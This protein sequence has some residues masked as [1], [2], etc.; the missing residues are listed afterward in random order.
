MKPIKQRSIAFAAALALTLITLTTGTPNASASTHQHIITGRVVK[1]DMQ[2]RQML[3]AD[4]TSKKLYL[5][6]VPKE[7]SLKILFGKNMQL[8]APALEDVDLQNTVLLRCASEEKEHFSRLHDGREVIA[9][10]AAH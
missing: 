9:L 4:R 2:E 1:I 5:V 3:V 8:S 6:N 7:A 10:R